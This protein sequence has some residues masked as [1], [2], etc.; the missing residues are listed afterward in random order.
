MRN[1]LGGQSDGVPF[2]SEWNA[3]PV[4]GGV[5]WA[6]EYC[7]PA[8]TCTSWALGKISFAY[9]S[10]PLL[11]DCRHPVGSGVTHLRTQPAASP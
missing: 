2:S 5:H 9:G 3:L 7:S 1:S 10:L 4:A 11:I 6:P 8:F